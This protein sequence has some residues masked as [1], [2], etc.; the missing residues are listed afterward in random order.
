MP[1]LSY[2]A[3]EIMRRYCLMKI[4][5]KDMEKQGSEILSEELTKVLG[6]IVKG[7]SLVFVGTIVALILYFLARIILARAFTV[8]EYGVFNL[9]LA[10][11]SLVTLLALMGIPDYIPRKI[12]YY[13]VRDPSRIKNVVSTAT[14]LILT[15]SIIISIALHMTSNF[16][17]AFFHD[18]RLFYVIKMLSLSIPFQALINLAISVFRG[19]ERIREKIYFQNITIP[20]L[21]LSGL[22]IIYYL[23]LPFNWV[24]PV[25][26]MVYILTFIVLLAYVH[27]LKIISIDFPSIDV[28]L[29]KN[30][31]AFSLPLLFT[32]VMGFIMNWTD[33][34]MI[35]YFKGSK[36][37]G[38][39]NVAAPLARLL[40][41]L[42][43]AAG[44]IFLPIAS[45]LYA[46]GLMDEMRRVYQVIT[47][48]LFI[49]TIP[50]FA[51]YVL[52]PKTVITIVFGTKYVGGY[53]ALQ[54]L[55][56]GFIFHVLVGL[57]GLSLIALGE[58]RFVALYT[59]ASAALNIILN[60]AL[61]PAY[62]INGA[63]IATA[64]SCIL[65]NIIASLKLYREYRIQ[66]FYSN[67]IK[68]LIIALL[69]LAILKPLSTL[70]SRIWNMAFCLFIYL[71]IFFSLII[72]SK[73]MDKEDI[74]L[75][76][77]LEKRLGTII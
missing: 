35:G 50:L 6:R 7:T 24:P 21:W 18:P 58:T 11:I 62:S 37:V 17:A 39:Y 27:R 74:G 46:K 8:S 28:G 60:L 57:N 4:E 61:I 53:Q 40:T 10:L 51:A 73:S 31:L 72:I 41:I 38:I 43:G 23:K 69:L 56:I 67:Y 59:L 33:T 45:E 52:F 65:A 12:S 71:V 32:G 3:H 47:K 22:L 68:T 36:L 76:K 16:L 64:S 9:A 19:F 66:P 77:A 2:E 55:S 25:Y 42:L 15:G 5:V 75:L 63:A 13:R 20:S 26:V 54:I 44:F 14:L 34:L 29:A 30:L 70:A 48:W 49:A 1:I